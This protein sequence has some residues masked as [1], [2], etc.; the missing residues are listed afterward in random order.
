MPTLSRKLLQLSYSTLSKYCRHLWL[1]SGMASF[2]HHS[3]GSTTWILLWGCEQTWQDYNSKC[4][5]LP[6]G[7]MEMWHS[8]GQAE[9]LPLHLAL[10]LLL[11][12]S[13][14]NLI[15][16]W[17]KHGKR[18]GLIHV[19]KNSSIIPAP[20]SLLL[21]CSTPCQ[22]RFLCLI[23]WFYEELHSLGLPWWHSG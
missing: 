20:R 5:T 23:L 17:C 10:V 1:F 14:R 16:E 12:L 22:C 3:S 4:R 8:L 2:I 18:L 13:L 21:L 9:T 6:G 11:A 7:E 15:L 19:L